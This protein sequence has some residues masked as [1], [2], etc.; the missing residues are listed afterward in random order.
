ML[1]LSAPMCLEFYRPVGKNHQ[2]NWSSHPKKIPNSEKT[3]GKEI[4][5]NKKERWRKQK[6]TNTPYLSLLEWKKKSAGSW[7][8]LNNTSNPIKKINNLFA[9]KQKPKV[10]D[11][12]PPG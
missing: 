10:E 11:I 2:S 7:D 4:I 5:T 3:K 8:N 1:F 12:P 9:L 6:E